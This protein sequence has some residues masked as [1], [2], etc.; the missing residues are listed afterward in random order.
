MRVIFNLFGQK[1]SLV[2]FPQVI[3]RKKGHVIRANRQTNRGSTAVGLLTSNPAQIS[4]IA[5]KNIM[6]ITTIYISP[7]P[8]NYRFTLSPIS[9]LSSSK[10]RPRLSPVLCLSAS[11]DMDSTAASSLYPLHRCKTLH[12]VRHAQGIHNVEGEKDYNAYLSYDL[13]DAQLTPLGLQQVDNLRKHVQASGLSKKIDLVITS[14][15]LRTM[16]TAV[17]V[18]GGEAYSDGINAPPLMVGN[19]GNSGRPAVTSLNCPP[20][21]AVELCRE[22][23]GVHP[24]DKRRSISEYRSL[25]PAIDFSL[26]ENNDDILWKPDVREKNEAVAARGLE[27][28]NWLWTREEKEIAIVSHS[29]FLYHTLSAFGNDC[30][31]TVKKEICTHFANC[32]LRSMVI[33]DRSLM[34][35]DSSTTNYPGKIPDGLDLPSDVAEEKHPDK[36]VTK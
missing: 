16:Q 2:S 3:T 30:H 17:G 7:S 18:F 9:K 34:G 14:P 20:F 5:Q 8:L 10:H 25:F 31:P 32:E 33:I 24:C 22:H 23:L 11:S 19:V 15:L 36:T 35:A 21:I 1:T 26:I 27:F 13:F 4:H 12:L 29:G 28:L 6:T